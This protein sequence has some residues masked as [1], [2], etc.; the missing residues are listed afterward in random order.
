MHSGFAP[1]KGTLWHTSGNGY[2]TN[3]GALD[4]GA[5]IGRFGGGRSIPVRFVKTRDW[6]SHASELVSAVSQLDVPS[7]ARKMNSAGSPPL[8]PGTT[9][10]PASTNPAS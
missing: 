4:N 9:A 2:T 3:D 1:T 8:T 7:H 5:T 6:P 10:L